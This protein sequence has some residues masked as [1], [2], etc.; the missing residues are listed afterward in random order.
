MTMIQYT[1][2]KLKSCT[3][4]AKKGCLGNQGRVSYNINLSRQ[5][6]IHDLE[7]N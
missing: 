6:D 1:T 4:Q 5:N 2:T 7:V 3:F